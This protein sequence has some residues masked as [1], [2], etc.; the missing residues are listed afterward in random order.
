MPEQFENPNAKKLEDETI[1]D[2][3]AGKRIDR[4]AEKAAE[5]ASKTEKNYDKEHG[6]ITH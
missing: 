6:V 3:S 2:A 4:V 1:S 5:K